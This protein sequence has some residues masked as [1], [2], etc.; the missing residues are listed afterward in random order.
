VL[1]EN[2]PLQLN[3][4]FGLKKKKVFSSSGSGVASTGHLQYILEK[5]GEYPKMFAT[6]HQLHQ[7]TQQLKG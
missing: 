3:Y 7:L 2:F 6:I 1:Y 4:F 5:F